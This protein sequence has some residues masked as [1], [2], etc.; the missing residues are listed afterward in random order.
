M[1]GRVVVAL[2]LGLLVAPAAATVPTSGYRIDHVV[3]GDTVV[4]ANGAKVRLVQIDSPEVYFRS[5]CYGRMASAC[6]SLC[7]TVSPAPPPNSTLSGTDG[8]RPAGQASRAS[9]ACLRKLSCLFE[10][11]GPA[12]VSYHD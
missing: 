7:R 5:E 2:L 12:V 11:R 1:R 9:F 6:S 4:L 3:D 10:G 8:R